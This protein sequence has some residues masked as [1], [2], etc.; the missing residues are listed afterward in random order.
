MCVRVCCALYRVPLRVLDP[1]LAG[2]Q[3]R[4]EHMSKKLR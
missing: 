1:T 2:M 4:L 3:Q